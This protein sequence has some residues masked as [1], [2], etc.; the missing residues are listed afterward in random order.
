MW[1]RKEE[2]IFLRIIIFFFFAVDINAIFSVFSLFEHLII[3]L[4]FF[5]VLSCRV[6][7]ELGHH[8]EHHVSNVG[9]QFKGLRGATLDKNILRMEPKD[10]KHSEMFAYPT[11]DMKPRHVSE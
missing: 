3:G 9:H 1:L 11:A 2:E 8:S 7:N 5:V 6:V 4:L 10:D